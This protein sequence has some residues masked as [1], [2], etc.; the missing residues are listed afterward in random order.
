[1]HRFQ[2]DQRGVAHL[3]LIVLV[4]VVLG[5]IGAAGW[6]VMNKNTK[7]APA[8]QE[9]ALTAAKEECEKENDKDICKFFS[10]WK[11]SK[12]YRMTSTDPSG[13]KSIFAVDGDKSHISMTG[14]LTYEVITVDKTTYTKSGETWYKQTIKTAE[15]DVS[16]DYKVDFDEP[17]DESKPEETKSTTTYMKIGK[18][19][20][21]KLTCFKYE[22]VD[23]AKAD[24][25]QYIWFDDR[26]YQLRRSQTVNAEGTSEQ[27]FEY[28]NVTVKIPSPV[29]ELGPNEYLVSGQAEP[30]TLPT[31]SDLGM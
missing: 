23:T 21:G 26:D 1:M 4:V 13:A 18:E 27:T 15:Q 30:M 3:A 17:A 25:K 29:K 24:E 22:I 8:A 7:S 9:T 28:D 14:E 16:S 5:A 2:T 19:A 12:K 10:S 20:C 6:Y 11:V 31:A